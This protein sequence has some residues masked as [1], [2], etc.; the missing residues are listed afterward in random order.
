MNSKI[1]LASI[2]FLTI[3]F[4]AATAQAPITVTTD[5][6]SYS[7]G[8][9]IVISG[10]VADQLNIPVSIVIRDSSQTPVYI[11]QSSPGASNTYTAQAVAGGSLW[12]NVGTYEIDVTYG[13]S[14][15]TAKTTFTFTPA[16]QSPPVNT[17]P[18]T[19]GTIPAVPEFGSLSV[20]IFA[21]AIV[22]TITLSTKIRSKF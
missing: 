13:G 7:D 9:T 5:K 2:A 17:T 3:S 15:K 20:I 10:T 22:S 8:D 4:M 14:D 6:T 11:A 19:N 18:Q 1:S 12:K 16:G 21:L